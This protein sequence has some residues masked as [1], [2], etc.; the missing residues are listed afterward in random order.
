MMALKYKPSLE[1]FDLFKYDHTH[2]QDPLY[3]C[4]HAYKVASVMFNSLRPYGL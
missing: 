4:I 2:I 3:P 1:N